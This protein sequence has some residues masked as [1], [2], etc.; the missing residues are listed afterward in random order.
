M[1]IGMLQS[2][3]GI[4]KNGVVQ[5]NETPPNIAESRVIVT[6]LETSDANPIIGNRSALGNQFITLGMFSGQNKSTAE[7]FEIAEFCGDLEDLEL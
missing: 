6:F 5:F 7:D 1:E 2:I 3:A 4:Y